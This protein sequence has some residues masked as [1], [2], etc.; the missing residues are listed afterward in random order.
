MTE[1]VLAEYIWMDGV[2]LKRNPYAL[3]RSKTRVLRCPV[4]HL[5]DIPGWSYDGSSCFQADGGRSDLLLK[6]VRH[7]A[8]PFHREH[9]VLVLCEVLNPDGSPHASNNRSRCAE[10]AERFGNWEFQ[11]GIEQEYTLYRHGEPLGWSKDGPEPEPQGRYYCGV[12]ADKAFGRQIKDAHL[13][14]C[15]RAGIGIVGTNGEVMPGQWEFQLAPMGAVEQSDQLWVARWILCR[16][17]EEFDVA[18]SF[19]PKPKEGDWNGAGAHTNFSTQAMRQPGGISAV[20]QA[21]A[22]L[23]T[24]HVEHIAVYGHGNAR[25]LTG[26]HETCDIATFRAGELDRGASVRIPSATVLNGCGYVEDRRPAAN[27]DPYLVTARIMETLC[28][29]ADPSV[30]GNGRRGA[31]ASCER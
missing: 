12:G 30:D 2:D 31:Y 21:C 1:R 10:M 26:R 27:M 23:E 20:R 7:F 5:Q 3:P 9:D 6:P 19:D 8:D 22:L 24:R 16:V 11:F 14:A 18:V 13:L 29:A 17:G 4:V 28:S 15:L 25:R